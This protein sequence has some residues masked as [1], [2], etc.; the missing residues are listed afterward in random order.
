MLSLFANSVDS[1]DSDTGIDLLHIIYSQAETCIHLHGMRLV[2]YTSI[3]VAC[4]HNTGHLSY[5]QMSYMTSHAHVQMY[6]PV[7]YYACGSLSFQMCTLLKP[8]N[9]TAVGHMWTLCQSSGNHHLLVI[10]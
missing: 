9:F 10:G 8:C 6:I 7:C 3:Q 4:T 2:I 1:A 5:M